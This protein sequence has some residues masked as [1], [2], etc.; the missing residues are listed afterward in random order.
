MICPDSLKLEKGIAH[1]KV[2][3]QPHCND[4]HGRCGAAILV[5]RRRIRP[6]QETSRQGAGCRHQKILSRFSQPIRIRESEPVT[7]NGV[8]FVVVAQTNWNRPEQDELFQGIAPLEIQL[9]ITNL[10]QNAVL[11]PTFKTFGI[12]V[13]N[14]DGKEVKPRGNLGGDKS[15]KPY[16][17]L[18]ALPI[19]SA[20]ALNCSGR[21]N[22]KQSIWSTTMARAQTIIGPLRAG[23]YKLVF[24]CRVS[25]DEQGK[26]RDS[27]AQ[28]GWR[29]R[30]Q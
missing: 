26:R 24:W 12:R 8:K 21:R 23:R 18:E 15:T 28:Y 29:D 2:D 20:G 1:E 7:A 14:A 6:R 17:S 10:K 4:R 13:L 16:Y 27:D 30:Y 3:F 11:F 5:F 19:Q 22:P 25:A 9:Q